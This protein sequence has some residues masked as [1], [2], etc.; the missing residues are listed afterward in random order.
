MQRVEETFHTTAEEE[1]MSKKTD[2]SIGK[3]SSR[4]NMEQGKYP[5]PVNSILRETLEL[6]KK[7]GMKFTMDDLAAELRMSKKTIY[8]YFKDKEQ[9]LDTMVD[10]FFD[11]VKD[12]ERTILEEPDLELTDRVRAVLGAMPE[13]YRNVDFRQLSVLRDKYPRLYQHM[14]D[15]L[16][17]GWEPTISLLEQGMREG[18]FR[19]FSIPVFRIMM[20]ASLEQFFQRDLLADSGMTYNE[21]LQEVVRILVD[22]IRKNR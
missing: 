6:F 2:S 9:L 11:A 17:S 15:R 21:A 18:V 16:E 3:D 8:V 12:S 14:V 7:R 4:K 22:G 1:E 10:Y 19:Q 5:E 20:Q 13:A